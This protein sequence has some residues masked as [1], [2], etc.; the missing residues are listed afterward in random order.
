MNIICYFYTLYRTVIA[1]NSVI[2]LEDQCYVLGYIWTVS[3]IKSSDNS[4]TSKYILSPSGFY[5]IRPNSVY[6]LCWQ[7]H[8]DWD[9]HKAHD[10]IQSISSIH[11]T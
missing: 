10:L 8:I 9:L 5:T 4:C 3:V 7:K 11:N 1:A 2:I 6:V